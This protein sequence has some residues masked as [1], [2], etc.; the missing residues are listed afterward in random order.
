MSNSACIRGF[1][2]ASPPSFKTSYAYGKKQEELILPKL[3]RFFKDDTIEQSENKFCKYDFY[4]K[5]SQRKIEQKSRTNSYRAFPTTLIPENKL[6]ADTTLVFRFTDGDYYIDYDEEL[7]NT[8][9]R[10]LFVCN[11]R[12]DYNDQP[13]YYYYIPIKFLKQIE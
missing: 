11:K 4:S 5:T 2:G 3:R 10:K 9:E 1:K 8:F 12:M 6:G 7:F 13:N